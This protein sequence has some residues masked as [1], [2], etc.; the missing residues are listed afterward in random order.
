MQVSASCERKA[1]RGRVTCEVELEVATGRVAW[2]DVV[3]VSAP[4]FAPPL[5]S[6]VG[7]GDARTRTERRVRIPVAFVATGTGRGTVV[8]RSRA[9]VCEAG[10]RGAETCRAASVDAQAELVVGVDIERSVPATP[11][12][13]AAARGG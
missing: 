3:V 4:A 6:R 5:R 1:A 8:L 10:E 7:M 11:N 2:A 13:A 12:L 9:A